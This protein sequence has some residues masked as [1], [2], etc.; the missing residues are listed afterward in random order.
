MITIQPKIHDRFT[1]EFKVGY[2]ADREQPLN[3]YSMNTWIFIPHSLDINPATYSKEAFY[4][5]L[6][7]NTRLMTPIYLLGEIVKGK[8]EPLGNLKRAIQKMVDNPDKN[9]IGEYEYIIKMFAAIYKSSLRNQVYYIIKPPTEEGR[10]ELCQ[11]L[12]EDIKSILFEY[13]A[14]NKNIAVPTLPRESFDYF[15]FGDEF[16]SDVTL[17][18]LFKLVTFLDGQHNGIYLKIKE[19]LLSL[20]SLESEHRANRGYIVV[21]KESKE[22]NRNLV[23]RS[24]ALK[25]YIESELFLDIAKKRDGIIVEQVYY[26][27]AAG[28]SMIFATAIAFSFQQRYGNFTVPLFVAL[29]VGYMLKDRIKE[30]FR[31]YFAHKLK[32]KYFDN[33]T[34][35]SLNQNAIGWSKEGVDFIQDHMLP[36]DVLRIRNRTPLLEA[37][38]RYT[39]EKIILFRKVL[40]LD[41]ELLDLNSEFYISGINE[42]LR[43]NLSTYLLK[44]DEP[45]VP[46]YILSTDSSNG[47]YLEVIGNKVYYLNFIIQFKYKNFETFKRY[48]VIFNRRG[49]NEIEELF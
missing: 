2:K 22:A 48:R 1:L 25:K 5:D 14:L 6:H 19:E 45:D 10:L 11:T 44:T 17:K 40:E 41:R 34:T 24:G 28:I 42:I 3:K 7:T 31:F 33:K 35:I 47:D 30:L 29:V 26:S 49:I 32:E 15:S 27:L 13:R 46:L 4:K 39:A 23:Y 37:D 38:N 43:F 20:I 16:I 18:W 21:E 36:K 9:S 12:I 8:G